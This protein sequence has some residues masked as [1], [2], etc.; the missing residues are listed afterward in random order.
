M[1]VKLLDFERDATTLTLNAPGIASYSLAP[2]DALGDVMD[3]GEFPVVL[4][5]DGSILTTSM[6]IAI[7]SHRVVGLGPARHDPDGRGEFIPKLTY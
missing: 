2:A 6:R 4:G 1:P 5:G 7:E 3:R